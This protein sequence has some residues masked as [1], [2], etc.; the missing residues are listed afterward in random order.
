VLELTHDTFCAAESQAG[1][2][3]QFTALPQRVVVRIPALSNFNTTL[4]AWP[5]QKG[6]DRIF[7]ADFGCDYSIA[8]YM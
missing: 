7:E 5:R 8:H 6:I 4:R 1:Q 2:S 3:E